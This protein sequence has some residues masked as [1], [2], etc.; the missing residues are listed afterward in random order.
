MLWSMKR[1]T[2]VLKTAPFNVEE[3]FLENESGPL[4]H[5]FHRISAPDW[6]NICPITADRQVVLI[7]QPRAGSMEMVLETPGGTI[8]PEDKDIEA[9]V[10]RELEEETGY[11]AQRISHLA[12]INPNPALFTNRIHLFLGFDCTPAQ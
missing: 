2:D 6:V 11:V 4:P 1:K 10:A 9:A 3:A 12:S 8:D 7:N 5:S